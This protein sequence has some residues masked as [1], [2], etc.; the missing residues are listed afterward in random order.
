MRA[1]FF[2]FLFFALLHSLANDSNGFL[3]TFQLRG[4]NFPLADH[5]SI[6]INQKLLCP[7]PYDIP[8]PALILNGDCDHTHLRLFPKQ[9]KTLLD[10]HTQ[11]LTDRGTIRSKKTDWKN[12]V[13]DQTEPRQSDPSLTDA[14]P[15]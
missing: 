12:H 11:N 1:I 9:A 10:P 7:V 3:L 13:N 15:N 2:Y 6:V 8:F 5:V 14:V 4:H